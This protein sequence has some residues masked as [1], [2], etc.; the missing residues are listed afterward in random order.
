MHHPHPPTNNHPPLNQT[1]QALCSQTVQLVLTAH[2]TQAFRQSLLKKYAR[3]RA[4]LDGLH[5]KRMSNYEKLETLE[6]VRAAVSRCGDGDGSGTAAPGRWRRG[7][8]EGFL[9]GGGG[10]RAPGR[11]G[12]GRGALFSGFARRERRPPPSAPCS[13]SNPPPPRSPL[14]NIKYIEYKHNNTTTTT[15]QV[16]AAWRTDEIRRQKPTP[17]DEMRHGLSYFQ[18]T[19]LDS[20]PV[21]MRR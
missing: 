7:G 15:R 8:R 2:P 11:G 9:G 6:A 5:S 17:Q 16:Q 19:I 21:F 4:L 10:G 12:G 14:N 20:L 1:K 3:V 18:S 13:R